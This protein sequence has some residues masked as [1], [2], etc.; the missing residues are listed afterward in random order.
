MPHHGATSQWSQ[1]FSQITSTAR[2]TCEQGARRGAHRSGLRWM[3]SRPVAAR[4]AAGSRRTSRTRR[5]LRSRACSSRTRCARAR[6]PEAG[7]LSRP[8]RAAPSQ[9]SRDVPP[10]TRACETTRRPTGDRAFG[11]Q[12]DRARI[13]HG[14]RAFE[15]SAALRER[16]ALAIQLAMRT[17]HVRNRPLERTTPRSAR[18]RAYCAPSHTWSEVPRSCLTLPAVC[19]TSSSCCAVRRTGCNGHPAARS[20]RPAGPCP[21]RPGASPRRRRWRRGIEQGDVRIV[22]ARRAVVTRAFENSRS[23]N[24]SRTR[25]TEEGRSIDRPSFHQHQDRERRKESR[26]RSRDGLGDAHASGRLAS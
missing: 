1:N 26:L 25:E 20:D 12:C 14:V 21:H 10:R 6:A 5:A 18:A 13:S 19:V 8:G 7:R 9:R 17:D 11:P 3:D 24:L 2:G 22:V 4:S 23:P 16:A 15:N